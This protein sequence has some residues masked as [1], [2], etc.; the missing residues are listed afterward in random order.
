MKPAKH[1]LTR[2]AAGSH[3]LPGPEDITRTE[4]ANGVCILSRTNFNSPSVYVTGYLPAGAIC[5]PDAHMGLADFTAAALMRGTQTHE[6][7]QIYDAL[8][9]AGA[10]LGFDAGAHAASFSGMALAEDLA[11]VLDLLASALR[12]PLFPSVQVERLRSQLLTGLAIRAQD[13]AA[14]ATL[15]FDQMVYKGHPYA[16]P[17]DGFPETIQ[18]ITTTHLADFHKAHYGP[19]GL[20]IA[21]VGAVEPQRAIELVQGVLGDWSNPAPAQQPLPP[22]RTLESMLQRRVTIPGK[23]QSDIVIGTAGPSRFSSDYLAASLGNNI[24]GQFGMYGRIGDVVREQAGL[25]YYA[26]S[27]LSGG[28]GPGPWYVTAGVDPANVEQASELII[29]EIGRFIGEPVAAEEL[30]DSQANYIGRLPLSLES[31]AGVAAALLNLERYNLG[32]DYYHRYP[33]L[34]AAITPAEVLEAARR[35]LDPERLAVA[36]AGP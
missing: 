10:S 19:G 24:L 9:S 27:S 2:H 8:E 11:M 16:R 6:F 22:V 31:N 34:I 30:A 36:V 33:D 29:S 20:V 21:V 28:P 35:Y 12:F 5:E 3:S 13:T 7:Q 26:Y 15:A 14:M 1:P 18:A 32:F 25:A 4:L 23:A 17:K